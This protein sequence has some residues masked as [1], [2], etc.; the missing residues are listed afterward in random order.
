[1]L[2]LAATD[3]SD[4]N[5]RVAAALRF[6][7]IDKENRFSMVSETAVRTLC[8]LADRPTALMRTQRECAAAICS[9]ADETEENASGGPGGLGSSSPDQQIR[10]MIAQQGALPTLIRLSK[11]SDTETI[12]SCSIALSSLSTASAT[13]DEGTVGSLIAMALAT[14]ELPDF[15][16]ELDDDDKPPPLQI[17]GLTAPDKGVVEDVCVVHDIEAQCDKQ[18]AGMAGEGPPLENLEL[19]EAGPLPFQGDGSPDA[20]AD[21]YLVEKSFPKIEL[22]PAMA[23]SLSTEGS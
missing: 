11:V 18:T 2:A 9:L 22:Q 13:V 8:A 5:W 15:L 1:M 3:T 10:T 4:G 12:K 19:M 21:E 14:T 23:N 16:T 20:G 7:A 6:L 17:E